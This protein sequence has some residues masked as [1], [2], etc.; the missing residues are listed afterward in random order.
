MIEIDLDNRTYD[1]TINGVAQAGTAFS[2]DV[3]LDT[4]R[5]FID[6][7]SGDVGFDALRIE[8]LP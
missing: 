6:H 7:A 1:T 3:A 8:A 2:N 5:L 4:V